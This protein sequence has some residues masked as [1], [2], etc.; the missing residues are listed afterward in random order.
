MRRVVAAHG[1]LDPAAVAERETLTALGK[2]AL[3]GGAAKG[4]CG[5]PGEMFGVVTGLVK[6]EPEGEARDVHTQG[7]RDLDMQM[8]ESLPRHA[9]SRLSGVSALRLPGDAGGLQGENPGDPQ[10][11]PLE[12]LEGL[13]GIC[14]RP[15]RIVSRPEAARVGV[16][17]CALG[18]ARQR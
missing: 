18:Y 14:G 4:D 9:L 11:P 17:G 2:E 16:P 1:F 8:V 5:L 7:H 6:G 15:S 12:G 3:Q 13:D 10:R